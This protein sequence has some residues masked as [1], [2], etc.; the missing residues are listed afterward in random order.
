MS[1]QDRMESVGESLG[2]TYREIDRQI[3]T[4]RKAI[5]KRA[6]KQ[7]KGVRKR[8]PKQVRHLQRD[9]TQ[10]IQKQLGGVLALFQLA[11]KSDLARIERRLTEINRKLGKLDSDT[12]AE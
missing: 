5:E 10:W 4:R 1:L 7:L 11:S 6:R 8:V 9:G 12:R 2:Q 3:S